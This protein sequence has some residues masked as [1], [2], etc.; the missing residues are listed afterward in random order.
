LRAVSSSSRVS[1]A[2]PASLARAGFHTS[3]SRHTN[4]FF[5]GAQKEH[6][7]MKGARAEVFKTPF[8]P[9]LLSQLGGVVPLFGA[10]AAIGITKEIL[11][12]DAELLLAGCLTTVYVGMYLAIGDQVKLA[13]KGGVDGVQSW[14]N[15]ASD[16]AIAS[17]ELYKGEQR[18]KLDA[19][20]T[21]QAYLEEYKDVMNVHA[22]A[23]AIKPRH[24]AREKVLAS[25][26]AIRTREQLAAAGQW[27]KFVTAYE[28]AVRKQLQVP[29]VREALFLSSIQMLNDHTVS[30]KIEATLE[31]VLADAVQAVDQAVIPE[32]L[33][34]E[35]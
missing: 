8:T 16:A 4:A 31:K 17:C 21:W 9:G 14:W 5:H 15:D 23:M 26:E 3:T 32:E 34:D 27:K 18:A 35:E 25:L 6:Y 7:Y 30:D 2:V 33:M 22:E 24:I 1:S 20:A 29:A 19:G 13:L 10:L 28:A 12:I 11:L